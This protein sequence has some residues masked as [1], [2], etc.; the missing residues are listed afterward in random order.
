MEIS[1]TGG[2]LLLA[3]TALWLG[4]ATVWAD[5]APSI[6]TL[7]KQ[8]TDA[9][10]AG[11]FGAADEKIRAAIALAD[12]DTF[13]RLA[14]LQGLIATYMGGDGRSLMG[15]AMAA[16]QSNAWPRPV[17]S[18]LLGE[19]K[20]QQVADGI[21]ISGVPI[22]EKTQRI[23]ELSFFAGAFAASD[24]EAR[25]AE[26]LLKKAAETCSSDPTMTALTAAEQARLPSAP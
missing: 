8:A 23:C 5:D 9:V 2:R 18:Y 17:I 26:K 13:M 15:A 25:F 6:A 1:L 19:R 11:E 24:G 21:R 4:T 22:A 12:N 20:L 14:L 3:A 16:H 7:E 10:I